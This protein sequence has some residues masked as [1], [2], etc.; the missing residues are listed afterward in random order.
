MK[1]SIPFPF[2][3]ARFSFWAPIAALILNIVTTAAL[4]DSKLGKLVV[5]SF[6]TLFIVTGF[7]M[8]IVALMAMRKHGRKG[9]FGYGVAG[10][11]IN[12]TI[13]ASTVAV[14]PFYFQLA[15][16]M[17][18]GI[19]EQEGNSF[20]RVFP[21]GRLIYNERLGYRF[22]IPNGFFDNPE[23]KA[24]PIF[25]YAFLRQNEDGS[26]TA[27][28]IQN[29]GGRIGREPW[30]LEDTEKMKARLPSGSK[31]EL[32]KGQWGGFDIEGFQQTIPVEG[33][34]VS[35]CAFQIP[36]AREAIQVNVGGPIEREE[37]LRE[38][39]QVILKSLYGKSNWQ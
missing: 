7:A 33:G 24:N 10:V 14:M 16:K 35:V 25:E 18:A 36:L 39:A 3:A 28:S 22:E 21:D 12:G 31:L 2:Q 13:L 23:A 26:R 27:I 5:G 4:A 11:L 37:E 9:L 32:L 30:R 6:C 19:T 1:T 38:I 29:L 20:A 8:A 34:T 17:K 15:Q